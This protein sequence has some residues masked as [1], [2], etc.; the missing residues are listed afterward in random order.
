MTTRIPRRAFLA[1]GAAVAGLAAAG[2]AAGGLLPDLAD[3]AGALGRTNG[4]GRNGISHSPPRRGGTL[5]YGTDSEVQG[6][7]PTSAEYDETGYTYG[8]CVFDPLVAGTASGGWVPYL[9]QSVVP[10]NDYATWVITLRPNLRFHDGTPC[11]GAALLL[12]IHK[13]STSLLTGAAFAQF[14]SDF[15]QTGPL[16]VQINMHNPWVAFPYTLSSQV[17]YIAAPSMLNNPNGT[18]HPVGTGPFVYQDWIPN[19]HFTATRN[20][21]YWRKGYPFLDTITFKPIADAGAR[22]DALQSGTIDMMVTDT[23]QSILQFRGNRQWAYVDNTGP[24]PGGAPGVNMIQL[25][26]SQPPMNDPDVR[27]ALAKGYSQTLAMRILSLG[28]DSPVNSPFV[29]GSAYYSNT[30]YPTYD[31][32]GA[33]KLVAAYQKRTGNPLSFTLTGVPDAGVQRDI[34]WLQQQWQSVGIGVKLDTN[35]QNELIDNAV[36]GKYQACTWRQFGAVNPDLNYVFWAANT[37]NTNGLS[38]NIARNSDPRIQ[39]AL[40]IGRETTNPVT[41]ARAYRSIGEYLAQ[42]LPYLWLGRAVWAMVATPSVKNFN[43]P[44]GPAGQPLIGIDGGATWPTQFWVS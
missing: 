10:S 13:Q 4:P 16:S 3:E 15:H 26:V 25:N 9:A 28:V 20:P 37:V 17:G 8:R 2:A 43:N 7:D 30:S 6:F 41:A 23:P 38:L 5:N 33:R 42:D 35:Q 31:P 36:A 22:T 44:A 18:D 14:V 27:L 24:V 21:N 29:P 12:N 32:A 1:R 39:K 11:D 34:T 19:D 40:D